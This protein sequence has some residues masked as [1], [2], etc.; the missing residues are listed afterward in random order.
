MSPLA[1][2][3]RHDVATY[4][5]LK[6]K[7]NMYGIYFVTYNIV[8]D[9]IQNTSPILP[10]GVSILYHNIYLH[11]NNPLIKL[12]CLIITANLPIAWQFS[13]H[14]WLLVHCKSENIFRSL[15]I[16]NSQNHLSK[17]FGMSSPLYDMS[18]YPLR[19][20]ATAVQC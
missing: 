19:T 9:W 14:M 4:S 5:M 11:N 10:E 3:E 2:S 13:K 7:H 6:V 18:V 15:K 20:L 17:S 16:S 12:N 8:I 1:Y